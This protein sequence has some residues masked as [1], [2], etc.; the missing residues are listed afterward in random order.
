[1]KTLKIIILSLMLTQLTLL[2]A[3]DDSFGSKRANV[4]V[5]NGIN[6]T[7]YY[8]LEW[9]EKADFVNGVIKVGTKFVGNSNDLKLN[10][11]VNNIPTSYPAYTDFTLLPAISLVG[12]DAPNIASGSNFD[13]STLYIYPEGGDFNDTVEVR[14]KLSAL[15]GK[16]EKIE[17]GIDDGDKR[18]T[19][20]T[21]TDGKNEFS[22]YLS[23]AGSHTIYY[24][25]NS[26][27][28][29]H[30][31]SFT[32]SN[33]DAIRD[34][35]GDGIP[36]S[37]EIELGMNP[38]SEVLNT[39]GWSRFDTIVRD[40]NLSDSDG[41]GWSDFD[42]T[43]LRYTDP[44]D[45]QSKPT[46]TSLYGIEYKIGSSTVKSNGSETE[47]D[48]PYYRLSFS[49]L[50]SNL[51]YD[52]KK[53]LD[54]NISQDYYNKAVSPLINGSLSRSLITGV[55]PIIR[56]P[57]DT[58]IIQ[59][60]RE[61]DD[62]NSWVAKIF[63]PSSND[64]SVQKYYQLF[65]ASKVNDTN[66]SSFISGYLE[67]LKTNLV[68]NK[69]IEL[70]NSTSVS[71]GVLELALR[72]RVESSTTLLLGNP[73][74]DVNY[75][76][77]QNTLKSL[78]DSSRAVNQLY[79]DLVQ[80]MS[81]HPITTEG[82][83][84]VFTLDANTTEFR[85]ASFMQKNLL[86]LDRYHISLMSIVDFNTSALNISVLNPDTDSDKDGLINKMEVFAIDYTNPLKADSDGDGLADGQDPCV[87]DADNSCLNDSLSNDDGDGDGVV[88]S[89]D[90]CPF[91][92]NAEQ[93]DMDFDGIGDVCAKKGIV[94][95][96]PRTN[97]SLFQGDSFSFGA[98]KTLVS[99]Q[100]ISWYIDG[101]RDNSASGLEYIHHF[102]KAGKTQICASLSSTFEL[103][104][105]SCIEVTLRVK[106]VFKQGVNLYA[107]D[108]KEGNSG[109][110]NTLVEISL[111]RS[112][113]DL[114]TYSYATSQYT[115]T[116]SEDYNETKG[117]VTFNVGESRKY[118]S[119][120]IFG[121]KI[122]ESDEVFYFTLSNKST[123]DK[124]AEIML[125][126]INDDI[127]IPD[128]NGSEGNT[129]IVDNYVTSRVF[130]EFEDATNGYE[131]WYSDGSETNTTILKDIVI[132]KNGS[133]TQNYIKV[134]NKTL[135]FTALNQDGKVSLYR[136]Y[137]TTESTVSLGFLDSYPSNFIDVNGI[138]YFTVDAK[139]YKCDGD[140][141]SYLTD[142][143]TGYASSETQMG[144]IF[145]LIGDVLYFQADLVEDDDYNKNLYKF[146]TSTQTRS[147]VKDNI[148]PTSDYYYLSNFIALGNKLYFIV[149]NKEIWQS[150]G[151]AGGTS[152]V[153]L[154]SDKDY[155]YNFTALN[156]ILYYSIYHNDDSHSSMN[157]YDLNSEVKKEL[158]S[159]DVN[160]SIHAIFKV[161]DKAYFNTISTDSNNSVILLSQNSVTEMFTT[162]EYINGVKVVGDRFYV[163]T[164]HSL[165]ADD[166]SILKSVVDNDSVWFIDDSIDNKLF[167][168]IV[169]SSSVSV[170]STD[171]TVTNTK[172]LFK[173]EK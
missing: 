104:S 103:K 25:L 34:S 124:V 41:D 54:I 53:R 11:L 107:F 98:K 58:P 153:T 84:E 101:I 64:A 13:K 118:I 57:A 22:I 16:I 94:I 152:L 18:I 29:T 62:N 115:A 151:T 71:V 55:I 105:A 157:S 79:S 45:N 139:L 83:D 109:S 150:D 44:E 119:I 113:E 161:G 73:D 140:I 100:D 167:F 162:S 37:V 7:T 43:I 146:D 36:D 173:Y 166:G 86:E 141:V 99:A 147:L 56:I 102:T 108:V 89:V 72:T 128:E 127:K 39:K 52:S 114:I 91:D 149:D 158:L 130:F 93:E 21:A 49:D 26:E 143:S 117:D 6:S 126:I 87:N 10:I 4:W 68:L 92:K 145:T 75:F 148:K 76:A 5:D 132:G 59:R 14:L 19:E 30:T 61:N 96:T 9:S 144:N 40:G 160:T 155:A 134:G 168:R 156:D 137:G 65:K 70:N 28:D 116:G 24:K 170:W 172:E 42:E 120:S 129:T 138:L 90:N 69:T 33:E 88:D 3:Y 67:Y 78:N 85:L 131:P 81:A 77:Y 23:R 163:F 135:Y 1:M 17:Y 122:Y 123:E 60:V 142:I 136:S 2:H 133:N 97:I 50:N 165:L 27:N 46:A 31:A 159:Y 35:D 82:L 125:S 47:K 95:T 74:F 106:N 171:S 32:I 20:L 51:L 48:L 110:K 80:M 15:S 8:L 154:I 38:L 169:T 164:Q 112:A 66:A 63:I 121:D 111:D 12:L